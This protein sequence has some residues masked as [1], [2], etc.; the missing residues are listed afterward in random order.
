MT[1]VLSAECAPLNV[2][3]MAATLGAAAQW[4][5]NLAVVK[6]TPYMITSLKYG[7]FFFFGACTVLGSIYIWYYVPETR[8][9]PMV[10]PKQLGYLALLDV[11]TLSCRRSWI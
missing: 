5:G 3:A 7:T 1:Y 11:K 9:L 2:R 8:G 4:L 10:S 6:A